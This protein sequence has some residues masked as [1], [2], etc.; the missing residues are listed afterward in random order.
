MLIADPFTTVSQIKSQIGEDQ[1][2]NVY[3]T[4]CECLE[5]PGRKFLSQS[6]IPFDIDGL[7]LPFDTSVP[8]PQIELVARAVCEAIGVS[9]DETGV[10]FSGNGLQFLI[11]LSEPIED[12]EYFDQTRLHYKAICDRINLALSVLK[13]QGKAD[14]S[15]WSPARLLRHPET[16]NR[17]AGKPERKSFAL[18]SNIVRVDFQLKKASGLPELKGSDHLN[19][20][21]VRDLFTCDPDAILHKDTGCDFLKFGFANPDKITEPFWYAGLS[22]VGRFP[23]GPKWAHD[24]SKGHPKYSYQETETK[25]KQACSE[26]SGPRTCKNIEGLGWNCAACPQFGKTHSPI[27]IEGPDSIKTISTGFRF[28]VETKDGEMRPGRVDY[29]GLWKFFM[30]T[31]DYVSVMDTPE[32]YAFKDNYWQAISKDNLLKFARDMVKPMAMDL[33]RQEFH[34]LVKVSNMVTRDFFDTLEDGTFNFKNGVYSLKDKALFPHS[35]EYPF[36]HILPCDYDETATAPRF[37]EFM[38]EITGHRQ[39]LEDLLQEFMGY[40]ISGMECKFQKGL[41][42]L[43]DGAN[44]KSTFINVVR[45]LTGSS[46]S[47]LSAKDLADDRKRAGMVGKLVNISEEN[48]RDSFREVETL[49]NMISGGMIWAK[50][51]YSQPFEFRNKAKLIISCNTLPTNRDV[52]N[53]FFRRLMIVPFD[54]C[55]SEDI[56]TAD[57]DIDEKLNDELAGIF[58]YAVEGYK[59]LLLQGKFT[60]PAESTSILDEYSYSSN[61]IQEWLKEEI[62]IIHSDQIRHSKDALYENYQAYCVAAGVRHIEARARFFMDLKHTLKKVGIPWKESRPETEGVRKRFFYYL[63]PK[64]P[65]LGVVINKDGVKFE[66]RD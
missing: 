41:L 52:T 61:P 21:A 48:S 49:K 1:L 3:Y 2:W 22:I 50:I 25:R 29:E 37:K 5:E 9:F 26:V 47:S 45:L 10:V 31:H 15:V 27:T 42:L 36:R 56:G 7:D 18:Q 43:G 40:V 38:K 60:K 63:R 14:P 8:R 59:R 20:K 11:G 39:P 6:H 34:K 24:F 55:F 51:L 53:G 17:K 23:E 30:R 65:T 44:G 58:N 16:Y 13:L 4:V 35:K 12:V 66:S 32:I 46:A 64:G 54:A 62:D 19:P 57:V 33:E 28:L